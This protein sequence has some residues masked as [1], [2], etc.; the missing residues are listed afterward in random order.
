MIIVLAGLIG[1]G[2]TT[3]AK[4]VSKRLD[5]PLYSI[6]DDKKKVYKEHPNY[7]YFLANNIPF[8]DDIRK[9]AFGA[10]LDGLRI[11]SRKNRHCIVE[12]TFHKK[13]IREPFF[14]EVETLFGSMILTLV[15]ADEA[16][17]RL[18]LKD[19]SGH[20]VGYGMYLSFR[21]QFEPFE[22]VDYTFDTTKDFEKT[23]EDYLLFLRAKIE[24][25][26]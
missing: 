18:R 6:D 2:K 21:E 20:M 5:I 15:T 9:K 13:N 19:R 24:K 8:P 14:A 1:V 11:L 17:V 3:I 23:M 7:D 4:E 12:E 10:A 25:R 16:T 26:I 22:H